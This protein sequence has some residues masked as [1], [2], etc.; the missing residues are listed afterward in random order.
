[1]CSGELKKS[2]SKSN[3]A[4]VLKDLIGWAGEKGK[5]NSKK[6]S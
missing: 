1:M 5:T 4:M 2:E 3:G 6:A